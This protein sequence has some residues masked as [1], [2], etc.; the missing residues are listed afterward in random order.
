MA[1]RAE[2]QQKKCHFD[3]CK[4]WKRWK[5]KI[6]QYK[7]IFGTCCLLSWE[8]HAAQ[9]SQH[10]VWLESPFYLR[11]PSNFF[12]FL[13]HSWFLFLFRFRFDS[14][15]APLLFGSCS[16]VGSDDVSARFDQCVQ[17]ESIACLPLHSDSMSMFFFFS[18]WLS[19]SLFLFLEYIFPF[20]VRL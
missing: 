3:H 11:F 2:Q 9:C 18:S 7:E 4:C 17:E 1:H 15:F 8:M 5:T 6:K 20:F 16:G 13:I 14:L 10:R 12:L 19:L